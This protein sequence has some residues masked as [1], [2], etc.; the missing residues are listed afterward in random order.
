MATTFMTLTR[1]EVSFDE[2]EE[3]LVNPAHIIEVRAQTYRATKD[4]PDRA[5]L[6]LRI[7]GGNSLSVLALGEQYESLQPAD[8]AQRKTGELLHLFNQAVRSAS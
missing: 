6:T 8:A 3:V 1:A 4:F 2:R 7:Q 5:F